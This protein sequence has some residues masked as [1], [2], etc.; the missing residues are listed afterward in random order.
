MCEL[1]L[2]Q[3][4]QRLCSAT[5]THVIIECEKTVASG[6]AR[7]TISQALHIGCKDQELSNPVVVIHPSSA[8]TPRPPGL[9]RSRASQ[10]PPRS[11]SQSCLPFRQDQGDALLIDPLPGPQ[12]LYPFVGGGEAFQSS[13]CFLAMS[14]G[15]T[16]MR[17]LTHRIAATN[18]SRKLRQG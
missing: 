12:A 7:R 17:L 4:S 3:R 15:S 11:H 18:A 5:A 6:N 1:C 9:R 14:V 10:S 8:R 13:L 2:P 16:P